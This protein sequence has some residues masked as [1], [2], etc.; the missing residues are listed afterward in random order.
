MALGLLWGLEAFAPAAQAA[1]AKVKRRTA[2]CQEAK[3]DCLPSFYLTP[4]DRIRIEGQSADGKWLHIRHLDS[5]QIGWVT[6]SEI[7][8][9]SVSRLDA[10]VVMNLDTPALGLVAGPDGL[11]MLMADQLLPVQAN[12][13]VQHL[14]GIDSL[15]PESLRGFMS[16]TQELRV[17]GETEVE[18]EKFLQELRPQLTPIEHYRTL[19]RLGSGP[20]TA[21]WLP[22]EQLLLLMG[23]ADGDWGN[24]LLAGLDAQYLPVMLV[25]T[26]IEVQGFLPAEVRIGLRGESLRLQDL[27]PDGT[28]TLSAYHSGLRR[29]VLIRVQP[30]VNR[31]WDFEG[32][33]YWPKDVP[34]RPDAAGLRLRLWH[35][36]EQTYLL[37]STP[38]SGPG[39]LVFYAG[40][41]EP[42]M[43]Q[44]LSAPVL[45]GVMYQDQLWTLEK[46]TIT[47]WQPIEEE[48]A[49]DKAPR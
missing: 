13:A 24:S 29:D 3:A 30:R 46:S 32:Q 26:I 15:K 9:Q 19:I 16:P 12:V 42:V 14:R 35:L 5:D 11:G 17:Y 45:D 44:R 7:Q 27:E 6:A 10:Q 34:F 8:L 22:D 25:R 41:S 2:F 49:G 48:P 39:Y 37:V 20:H 21:A 33:Y 43:V 28:L 4:S 38:D 31:S 36:G 18:K 47:R 1:E 40:G 23:E